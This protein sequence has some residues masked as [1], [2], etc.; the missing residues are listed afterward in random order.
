MND[1]AKDAWKYYEY[2]RLYNN[3]LIPNQYTM[4]N[5]NQEFF[6]GNQWIHMPDNP[7]MRRLAKPT[8]NI[9]KRVTSLFV[10]SLTS[11]N[12]TISFEPLSYQN[13]GEA[14]AFATA[15]VRNLLEKFKMDYRIRDALFD[16]AITG[17]YAAHFYWNPEARPY[18]GAFGEYLGY[19]PVFKDFSEIDIKAG[20]LK[21]VECEGR[22][23]TGAIMLEFM[24]NDIIKDH[25]MQEFNKAFYD[26]KLYLTTGVL[27]AP[28]IRDV[29]SLA[30]TVSGTAVGAGP[31]LSA[32]LN[33]ADD[34]VFGAL[35]V[36]MGYQDASSV[37]LNLGK[38]IALTGISMGLNSA[39]SFAGSFVNDIKDFYVKGFSKGLL[40]A[41]S[42]YLSSVASGYVNAL[43]WDGENFIYD[44][45]TANSSWYSKDTISSATGA[46]VLSFSNLMTKSNINY[47]E[48]KFFGS[49]IQLSSIALSK[50]S[51]FGVMC[52][53]NDGNL[54]NAFDDM[55]LTFNVL[56]L[57]SVFDLMDTIDARIS[58]N[59]QSS[60][61]LVA[62]ARKFSGTG[63]LEVNLSSSGV[64]ARIGS[65]GTNIGN[66]LDYA[67]LNSYGNKSNMDAGTVW[68]NYVYGDRTQENTSFRI[69][70]HK[71]T[72][73]FVSATDVEN[74]CTAQTVCNENGGRTITLVNSGKVFTNAISLGHESYRNG[75]VDSLEVQQEETRRAVLAHTEE[76]F[77]M[78]SGGEKI[79]F[80]GNLCNDLGQYISAM[81]NGELSKFYEYIEKS[82]D[83]SA[84]YWK[85]IVNTNDF[86]HEL[87]YD[88]NEE[89]SVDY[90][91]KDGEVISTMT[92]DGQ[93]LSGYGMSGSLVKIIGIQ[94]AQKLIGS[95]Y[96]DI[97]IYD[98]ETLRDV[99]SKKGYSEQ[100]INRMLSNEDSI[101]G[102]LKNI[103]FTEQEICILLGDVLMKKMGASWNGNEWVNESGV[104]LN[105]SNDFCIQ[106]AITDKVLNGNILA[107]VSSDGRYLYSTVNATI[108]RDPRSLNSV[109]SKDGVNW[110]RNTKNLGLDYVLYKKEGINY[111]YFDAILLNNY[112]TVDNLVGMGSSYN[113]AQPYA[114]GENDYVQG[115]TIV[116]ENFNLGY[117]TD[118]RGDSS[119]ENK[120]LVANNAT[121]LSG[122]FIGNDGN[123]KTDTASEN[124]IGRWL[125]HDDTKWSYDNNAWIRTDYL[126][127]DG[128]CVTDVQNQ[129]I[130]L[131]T[132]KR[133]NV[134]SGYQIHANLITRAYTGY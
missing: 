118:S 75:I 35:D 57:G 105:I 54:Q 131:N 26:K 122:E 9:I 124:L 13:D 24:W 20:M 89:L 25:G 30:L 53:Y 112:Q 79:G 108:Y 95:D 60:D 129:I 32:A 91:D 3:N 45:E 87:V 56:D 42:S 100:D 109:T 34:I 90:I 61:F 23:E 22:G 47:T 121:T 19:A 62:N 76:A 15:E 65:S 115:N 86:T 96:T 2:G 126:A 58:L 27:E 39:T 69:A 43:S 92:P 116:S 38:S 66:L 1:Y 111:D 6:I 101:Q 120:V 31:V 130:L 119:F 14:A 94:Q 125:F 106:S 68:Y 37:A 117:Y 133:W 71:D 21:N 11:S 78:M 44:I 41:S 16:G 114:R 98:E 88:G 110:Y 81:D 36:T 51:E 134:G 50:A 127:S 5:T 49:A 72:L 128:C 132:L 4:V 28:T 40:S 33:L 113:Y 64:K 107:E 10:A 12:T 83:S 99:L 97:S 8:F 17:D 82:Y 93:D 67:V 52:V 63:L 84:D 70:N 55:S 104:S 73:N 77:R 102:S 46:G 103:T 29:A 48:N 80:A 74:G 85:L 123:V 18:G 59:G 7:A